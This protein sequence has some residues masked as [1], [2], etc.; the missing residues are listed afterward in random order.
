M[1]SENEIGSGVHTGFALRS[2]ASATIYT[3]QVILIF[4]RD[5]ISSVNSI[6]LAFDDFSENL[7]PI[8]GKRCPVRGY[9]GNS[10]DSRCTA[11]SE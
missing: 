3:H 9:D 10:A 5:N 1:T 7:T 2:D 8:N 4:I 6:V 11:D